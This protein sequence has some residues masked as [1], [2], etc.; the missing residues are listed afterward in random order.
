MQANLG[1]LDRIIADI[2][3]RSARTADEPR[4]TIDEPDPRIPATNQV[5]PREEL[6][7]ENDV[8]AAENM[9]FIVAEERARQQRE[10]QSLEN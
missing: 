3:A 5:E 10:N 1:R 2:E 8:G 9:M 7:R 4:Q 6:S